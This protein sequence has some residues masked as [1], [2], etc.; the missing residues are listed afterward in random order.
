MNTLIE[1][2]DERAIENILAPDM[3]RPQRIVY[4][5][6][7]EIVRDRMRQEKLAAFFQR[8]IALQRRAVQRFK[9]RVCRQTLQRFVPAAF[10]PVGRGKAYAVHS[11]CA[12]QA[13][14]GD[15]APTRTS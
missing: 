5:C 15:A 3:F 1:L 14:V 4:L 12:A 9:V 13:D 8:R 6:P 7:G 10:L 11:Q 2:Y